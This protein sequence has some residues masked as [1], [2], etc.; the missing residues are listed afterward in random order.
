MLGRFL[1]N[2]GRCLFEV[3]RPH[4][5]GYHLLR[6]GFARN[7]GLEALADSVDLQDLGCDTQQKVLTRMI[8]GAGSVPEVFA[9]LHLRV[10]LGVE[11]D[12]IMASS[13][14]AAL[15]RQSPEFSQDVVDSA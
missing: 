12:S 10:T 14:L 15:A 1:S 7:H 5:L 9:H 4:G 6:R 11:F 3:G 8:A 2:C 13:V